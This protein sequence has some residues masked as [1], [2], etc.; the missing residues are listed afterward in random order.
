MPERKITFVIKQ[1]VPSN[2][3]DEFPIKERLFFEYMGLT[4]LE[5]VQSNPLAT[6]IVCLYSWA[7]IDLNTARSLLKRKTF[8]ECLEELV[9][10]DD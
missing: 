2:T 5:Y 4:G 8:L 7:N 6:P 1:C 9:G 3:Y 10:C